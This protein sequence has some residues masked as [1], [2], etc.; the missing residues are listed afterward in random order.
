ML[1]TWLP[2]LFPALACGTG[3]E[4]LISD[5]DMVLPSSSATCPALGSTVLALSG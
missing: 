4:E 5:R 1:Q 3:Q 2:V